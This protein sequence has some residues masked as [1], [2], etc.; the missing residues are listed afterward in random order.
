LLGRD[1]SLGSYRLALQILLKSAVAY[2]VALCISTVW[3]KCNGTKVA[4][5]RLLRIQ[6]P[7]RIALVF[8]VQVDGRGIPTLGCGALRQ[9]V[10]TTHI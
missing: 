1:N 2:P 3:E 8:L 7:P 9:E 5:D 4:L 10:G 6:C